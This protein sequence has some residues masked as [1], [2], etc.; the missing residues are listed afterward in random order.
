MSV[1]YIPEKVRTRLWGKAGGRC[2][3]EGCNKP[4]WFDELIKLEFNNAYI[5]HI[6]AD[7]PDG[8]RGDKSLS[9]E[10]KADTSNL[11]LLCDSHHRLVDKE[12]VIGHP[13][14]RLRDM[15]RKH[16][17]RV[18]LLTDIQPQKQSNIVLY[19]ARI[20]EHHTHLSFEKAAAAMIPERYPAS[21]RAIELSLKNSSFQDDEAQYWS[22]EQEHLRRQFDERVKARLASGEIGHFSVFALAPQP[23]LMELGAL[24]SDISAA[25]VYQLHREPSDW[26]WQE[27]PDGFEYSVVEPD[28]FD[29][30]PALNMSLSA[31]II[32]DRISEVLKEP[33]SVWTMTIE[34]VRSK[35]I[36]LL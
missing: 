19:G 30:A 9:E 12:D 2:E 5:A 3:Y 16:E 8:P 14:E 21:N 23:L 36:K 6:I 18:E 24:L 17:A 35:N 1:A 29:G 33:H 7:K 31:T 4:L 22:I 11:M 13:V 15:K 25:E 26:R 34:H 28:S 32:S 20:G 10:L 27:H